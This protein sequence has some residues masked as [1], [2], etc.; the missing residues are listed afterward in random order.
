MCL[1]QPESRYRSGSEGRVKDW[2]T[3]AH[4]SLTLSEDAEGWMIGRGVCEARVRDLGVRVWDSSRLTSSNDPEFVRRYGPLGQELDGR[5][6]I[7]LWSPRGR[8][9]GVETRTWGVGVDKKLDQVILPEAKWNPVFIGLTPDAMQKIWN[10]CN[11]WLAEGVFD[12]GAMEHV[13]PPT[14]VVLA[15]VRARVSPRHVAFFVRFLINGTVYMVYDND[16]TGRNQTLGYTDPRTGKYHW[17]ALDV[18]K[19]VG[20]PA[21]DMPYRG[22]KDPGAIWEEQGTDG[23]RRSFSGQL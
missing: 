11:V 6:V 4:A 2:L 23:L 17:G 3:Q 16:E 13:V 7:P 5:L 18:F 1:S 20:I 9:L 22:G 21:H 19:R 8:L 14:D 15:T 10:G 12:M